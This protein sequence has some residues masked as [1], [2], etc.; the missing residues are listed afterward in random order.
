MKSELGVDASQRTEV[1]ALLNQIVADEH[2]LYV[3]LR[4]FHWNVVGPQFMALHQLYEAQYT[5]IEK[6]NDEIAERVRALGGQAVGTMSE[7]A[8]LTQLAEAPGECPAANE[9]T[10]ELV[11]DHETIVRSLRD[12]IER[13]SDDLH[14]EGTADLLT[15]AMQEHMKMAWMLRS[16]LET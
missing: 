1:C 8:E 2:V 6:L 16:T 4:K 11:A 13:C 7:F 5:A 3:K 14:E 15:G 12:A 9:M 10:A